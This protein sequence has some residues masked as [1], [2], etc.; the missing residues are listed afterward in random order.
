MRFIFGRAGTGKSTYC[1]ERIITE[2][3]RDPFGNPLVLLVP[4][5]ATHQME[6]RLAQTPELGGILRA[7][8]LSFRRL[9]WRIFSE[10]GG[11]QRKIIG[12][13]GKRML[14]R[15]LLLQYKPQLQIFA[16]SA[17]RPGMADLLAQLIREFKIYRVTPEDLLS[18]QDSNSVLK[19]K[20]KEIALLYDQF[21]QTLGN[22]ILDPDD[23]LEIVAAKVPS[24]PSL[25]KS[26]VWIDGFKGFTPQ[27]LYVIEYLLKTVQ[28]VILTL[29]L[30][31]AILQRQE[32]AYHEE[33]I[34][35]AGEEL[36]SGPWRTYQSLIRI[37]R[38]TAVP[39][40]DPVFLEKPYRFRN[41]ELCFLEKHYFMY[42]TLSYSDSYS[43]KEEDQIDQK[44]QGIRLFSAV[45][46]REEV[47][48]VAREL[49]RLAREEGLRWSNMAVVTRD[50]SAYQETIQHV[51]KA[52]DLPFFLD[53]KRPI[54]HHPL[55]ELLMSVLEVVQ[56]DWAY[57][58]LFRALKTGF[59]PI[60]QDSIDSLENYCLAYGIRGEAWTS[61]KQWHYQS[62]WRAGDQAAQLQLEKDQE[63][64][65]NDTRQKVLNSLQA[66]VEAASSVIALSPEDLKRISVRTVTEALYNLLVQLN[67]PA[68]LELWAEEAR[69]AGNLAE[70]RLQE[71]IWDAVIEVFDEMITGLGEELLELQEYAIILA[72][73]LENLK[74]GLIP[75]GLD[76]ILVG[77]LDR[78]RNPELRI[79][80]L[81]GANE[82]ILPARP[83]CDGVLDSEEREQLE[84]LGITLAPKG[85]AQLYEEQFF[86]YTGLTQARDRLYVSYPLTDEEG[87][88]LT[89]SPVVTRLRTLFP[90]LHEQYLGNSEDDL[91]QISHPQPL[92]PLYAAQLLHVRQHQVILPMWQAVRKWYQNASEYQWQ[93]KLLEAGVSAENHEGK[94]PKR[95]ARRLYGKRL[96][97]SVSRLEEFARCPFAHY[98]KYGLKLKER[99][100]YQLASPD[101]G[102][103]FHAVLRDFA[104]KVRSENLDWGTMTKEESW[105][106][107][108]EL[109]EV[110]APRL[111]N[112]ILLS[113]ARYRYLKHK[114]KRTVHHAVRVLGEHARQGS[115]VPIQ[116][117]VPF[118]PGKALPG[119]EVSLQNENSLLLQGQ[120]DR[121]DAAVLEGKVY[122]RIMDY[123]SRQPHV[124][125]DHIFYGLDLQLLAYLDAALQGAEILLDTTSSEHAFFEDSQ[126]SQEFADLKVSPAGF[127]YFP[128]VEPQ[129]NSNTLLSAEEVEAKRITAVKVK[130]FLLADRQVLEAMDKTLST[131]Q[132]D[133]LGIKLTKT[134]EF[135]KNANILTQDQFSL[136][137]EHLH[138]YLR[139]SGEEIMSGNIAISPYRQ[140]K[141]N[142]CQYCE[143]K[144][145]CHF[146]SYLPENQYRD[147]PVLKDL[148][149]WN[150]IDSNSKKAG[151]EQD[152][153][154]PE[155]NW[156]GDDE[157]EAEGEKDE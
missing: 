16:R 144:P 127:L 88:A 102:Q 156:L 105:D 63:M 26:T 112:E 153:F 45:N 121:V 104:E 140:G 30:D 41:P 80:F 99:T 91:E 129:L 50:L 31:P 35:R 66:F 32:E 9:G 79:L 154:F 51:F 103:F 28:D 25:Q 101:M 98:S 87:K 44:K 7:Q 119:I 11:G 60:S 147:L 115:F 132:S 77:S 3:Q 34:F 76:Q 128:V 114:L 78:S 133:L 64:Q 57:E 37:A 141:E 81:L 145:V 143:F 94:V 70:A 22:D 108:S 134:M 83:V 90:D 23:E 148:E 59:F 125:L 56:K 58:P 139:K 130:G 38:E 149:V 74:L 27:E 93:V 55:L 17:T 82:G 5:Q 18:I 24:S 62:R 21:N 131:G 157:T 14:L 120:I 109:A 33:G 46:R 4:E 10:T 100:I 146:D 89:V 95:L 136:L 96:L 97:A 137:R 86:V 123:K 36:F 92:L 69:D 68:T 8:V 111:Q 84:A 12:E 124:S 15:R 75:P 65:I 49:R 126:E 135:R 29:P 42:P 61:G 53:S 47:H 118:G 113:N 106:L 110:I 155:L 71:Q 107:V 116:L 73:G 150:F 152:K 54:L 72:S 39:I 2:I 138:A 48:G 52:Y 19:R 13:M 122:L 117:E 85:R 40:L 67:V 20:L 43:D 1:L 6:M 142:A 151:S